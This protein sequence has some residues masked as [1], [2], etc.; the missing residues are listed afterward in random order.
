MR[1]ENWKVLDH[2]CA[3]MKEHQ[4]YS[5]SMCIPVINKDGYII[6]CDDINAVQIKYCPFCGAELAQNK[7]VNFD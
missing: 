1:Y 3:G 2:I 4:D 6:G 7:A 5:T